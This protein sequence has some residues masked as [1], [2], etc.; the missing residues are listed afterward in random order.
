MGQVRQ[1][2]QRT[3]RHV[4]R[5]TDQ[6]PHQ[7]GTT[8]SFGFPVLDDREEA[9]HRQQHLGTRPQQV[10]RGSGGYPTPGHW[11]PS[12]VTAAAAGFLRSAGRFACRYCPAFFRCGGAEPRQTEAPHRGWTLAVPM[13]CSRCWAALSASPRQ[14]QLTWKCPR[15]PSAKVL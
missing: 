12:P 9:R 4:E 10:H 5:T 11:H 13:H 7:Y 6:T 14:Q 8:A 2:R 15:V 1:A 3:P